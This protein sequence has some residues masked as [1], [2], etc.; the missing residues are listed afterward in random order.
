MLP[1]GVFYNK[2]WERIYYNYYR[3]DNI[4]NKWTKEL[5]KELKNLFEDEINIELN[6]NKEK[7]NDTKINIKNSTKD[8]YLERDLY[9]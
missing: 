2:N 1:K 8:I 3:V 6:K 5:R 4:N 7:T 9:I